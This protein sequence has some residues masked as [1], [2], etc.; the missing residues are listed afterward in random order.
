MNVSPL[1]KFLNTIRLNGLVVPRFADGHGLQIS[2]ETQI[3]VD[4]ECAKIGVSGP[5]FYMYYVD[6]MSNTITL[7]PPFVNEQ[8][9]KCD[10]NSQTYEMAMRDMRWPV[11]V[12]DCEKIVA[13]SV[14]YPNAGKGLELP[15]TGEKSKIIVAK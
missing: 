4:R 15:A 14:V 8:T 5:A 11:E 9:L 12:V 3:A 2:G 13:F 7:C 6:P 1:V 10:F